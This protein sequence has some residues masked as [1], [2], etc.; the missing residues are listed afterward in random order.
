MF[1]IMDLKEQRE[2]AVKNAEELIKAADAEAR[3]LSPEE[4]ARYD[5]LMDTRDKLDK[6]IEQR[7]RLQAA[8]TAEAA[9]AV[10]KTEPQTPSATPKSFTR[11]E[12][13][14]PS[15]KLRS[16]KN[17]EQAHLAGQ[18]LR[19]ALFNNVESRN[20]CIDRGLEFR[21]ATEGVNTAGG[22]LVPT[23]LDNA[24]EDNRDAYGVFRRECPPTTMSSDT[25]SIPVKTSGLT[26]YFVGENTEPT[27]STGVWTQV[28]L[29]AKKMMVET[30][31]SSEVNDDAIINMAE[32]LSS[33]IGMAFAELEDRCGFIGDGT[34]TY[35]GMYG[36]STWFTAHDA[37]GEKGVVISA[38]NH[39]SYSEYDAADIGLVKAA[40]KPQY[41]QGAK[42]YMSEATWSGVFE[43]LL[44][45]A[46]GNTT[47]M[48]AEGAQ[49]RFGGYPVV[50]SEL[51]LS[52]ATPTTTHAGVSVCMFGNL[53]RTSK[54]G[55]RRGTTIRVAN[56]RYVE[57]DQIGIFGSSRFDIANW[58]LGD[59]TAAGGMVSLNAV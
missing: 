51:L 58:N 13:A 9:P 3:D 22:Y 52:S 47:A 2:M 59:T 39:D 37:T 49:Y 26:A 33:D 20:F 25:K 5:V 29:T 10:R 48:L 41:R 19:G 28:N 8:K 35:G 11:I 45:A 27:E 32:V 17:Y 50:I 16:F 36:L 24:I 21:T 42:W 54:F 38:T 44:I 34:S 23:E 14:R 53:P 55:V 18:W 4:S 7:E 40:L 12:L 6:N 31:Y 57:L 15:V 56:E 30:L 43:R 1:G 46:G